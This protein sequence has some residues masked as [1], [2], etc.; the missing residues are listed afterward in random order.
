MVIYYYRIEKKRK[1]S[2]NFSLDGFF[3]MLWT[4]LGLRHDSLCENEKEKRNKEWH[5]WPRGEK[6]HHAL[7]AYF[8]P[9]TWRWTLHVWGLPSCTMWDSPPCEREETCVRC[10]V[11]FLPSWPAM[12]LFFPLFLFIFTQTVTPQTQ[13]G[14]KYE[15]KTI[16]RETVWDFSFLFYVIIIYNHTEI[17]T[18]QVKAL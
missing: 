10:M 18:L 3:L 16:K 14:L 13:N 9:L 2:Y 11:N 12:S 6:I 15:K 7:N 5:S 8:L 1:I 4:I 17:S